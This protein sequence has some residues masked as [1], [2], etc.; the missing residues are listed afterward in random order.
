MR[1]MPEKISKS[2]S[3]LLDLIIQ[4]FG[5]RAIKVILYGSYA[6]GD[7]KK[8]ERCNFCMDHWWKSARH[9]LEETFN[10]MDN[11]YNINDMKNGIMTEIFK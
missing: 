7:Y 8:Y 9:N 10:E 2:I 3:E 1:E 11:I 5:D 4:V 6:R